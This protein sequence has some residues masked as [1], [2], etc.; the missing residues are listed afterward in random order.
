[1]IISSYRGL[2]RFGGAWEDWCD[3]KFANDPVNLGK[4]K[5]WAPFAPW[6]DV[7][8]AIRGIPK[9]GSLLN[10]LNPGQGAPPAPPP[11]PQTGSAGAI[12]AASKGVLLAG[13]AL[14]L[15][16]GLFLLTSKSRG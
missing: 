11:E 10:V 9:P 4:C 7:G 15:V 16:G 13:G 1:M 12:G 3:Q 6:T 14:L 5:G 8:A 2:G